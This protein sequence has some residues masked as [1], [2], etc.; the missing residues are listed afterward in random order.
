MPKEIHKMRHLTL[1]LL[2]RN[3]G[4][5]LYGIFFLILGLVGPNV[6]GQTAAVGL[7][8][9]KISVVGQ[10]RIEAEAILEKMSLKE[11]LVATPEKVRS[12]IESVF[13][14]GFFEDVRI[15]QNDGGEVT[16]RVRERPV[17]MTISYEGAG[18]FE[19]KDLDEIVNIKPF[20]VLNLTKIRAA[21]A[22]IAAKYEE[23][24]FYLARADYELTPNPQKP[25]EIS[26]KF[27]VTENEK[28][29]VRRI[30]FSGNQKFT[31]GDLKQVMMTAEGHVFSWMTGGG[32]YREQAFE[33][34]L[35]V[36][37]Y[38]YGNE[39][40]IQAKFE[41][42]RVSISQDRRYI[43]IYMEVDEGPQFFLGEVK[44]Q[45]ESLLFRESDLRQSFEMSE[46]QIFSTGKLQ[47]E[48]LR[49][50]DKYGDEGYAF[51]NVIPR[52]LIRPG[53]EIVDLV[54]DIEKGEKVY[55]GK[56]T[57]T[58]NTKTHDKVIRRELPFVEGELYNAT[59]RK[60]GV[61]KVRRL[62]FFGQEVN[63]LTSTPKGSTDLLDL[64]IRVSEKPTG[65][66]NVSAG[67]GTGAGFTLRGQ[68]SQNNLFGR[69][70]Y[71]A[72]TL[73]H[74]KTARQFD[75]SFND[76]KAFDTEW[77][78]GFDL[79]YQISQI[80]GIGSGRTYD[81]DVVGTTLRTGRELTE[82]LM[83]F[84]S[85]KLARSQIK[86]PISQDIITDSKDLDSLISSVS[87]SFS[88]DTRN[89]RLDPFKGIFSTLSGEFAGLGGRIFQKYALVWR[90]YNRPIWKFTLRTNFE[91]GLLTNVFG[92]DPVPVSERYVLGYYTLRGYPIS[93]VGPATIVT[94]DRADA[95]GRPAFP[96]VLGGTRKALLSQEVEFPIIPEA[97]IRG[98]LFFDTGN[99]WD[100]LVDRSPALLSNYGWGFRWYSPLGPLR[101]EFGFPL[102]TT[103][104]KRDRSPEFIF[105]IQ[106]PF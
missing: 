47:E 33:R 63:F 26:L 39:G 9:K 68:V 75:L 80:G 54:I 73:T 91:L 5:G 59:K 79:Y 44:F 67:Y 104:Q 20:T 84:G 51:A 11:G 103:P 37:A 24:G 106:P 45:G 92:N 21:Q 56:I 60:R 50:T 85:Y 25:S 23:K 7:P 102:N 30:F 93:S 42:P 89:N 66:L 86:N 46:G 83:I 61:E 100:R 57:V 55:W 19:K 6:K 18:E 72:L 76:P 48:I 105:A 82:D 62:G 101:I 88:Y 3:F 8:V 81:Q 69:G 77:L 40:Y 96:Y 41:K 32:T 58:G 64:E 36:L 98:V 16:V 34:D 90:F 17:V 13:S 49:L 22:A 53:T 99:T 31:T 97:D 65:S 43:D 4:R 2:G 78:M 70:Q 1:F 87:L 12:D 15:Y 14:L 29:R 28:V 94:P 35:A 74:E 71:L 95:L 10:N 38:F 52:P 27:K